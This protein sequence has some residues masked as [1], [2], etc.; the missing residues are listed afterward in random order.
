MRTKQVILYSLLLIALFTSCNE[1]R[2]NLAPI[3]TLRLSVDKNEQILTKGAITEELLKVYIV[4]ADGDT[5]KSYHDYVK[6]VRNEKLLLPVGTYTVSVASNQAE[7]ADWEK[8]FYAGEETVEVK[9]GEIT[10]ATV[11][12]KIANTKVSVDYAE[13]LKENFVNYETTVSNKSGTLLYA[14]DEYRAGYFIPEKLTVSLALTNNN[15]KEYTIRY[16]LTDIK[17]RYH[18]TIKF[19]IGDPPATPEGGSDFDIEVDDK[20]KVVN[21][22]IVIHENDLEGQKIPVIK[23]SDAFK[24]SLLSIKVGED[25][26]SSSLKITSQVGI[27]MLTVKAESDLF[28]TKDLGL[29]DL[30]HL[31]GMSQSELE[32]LGFPLLPQN[33]DLKDITLDFKKLNEIFLQDITYEQSKKLHVFTVYAMDSLHQETELKFTIEAKPDVAIYVE[34]PNIWTT[35]AVLKGFCAE[36]SYFKLQVAGGSVIDVKSVSSDG[37]GNVSALVIGLK[38][39]VSYKY[40]LVSEEN[41]DMVCEPKEFTIKAPS[42]VPNFGFENWGKH[43][44]YLDA[45]LVGGNKE[46]ISPNDENYF[47]ESGNLGAIA[48]SEILTNETSQTALSSSKKAAQLTSTWAGAAGIGAYAAGSIYSGYPKSVS[49]S[50]AELVYGRTYQGFPTK[51]RGY[52]KYEPHEIGDDVDDRCPVKDLKGK[53]DQGIIYIALVPRTFNIVS[54]TSGTIVAFNKENAKAFAYGEYIITETKN[55]T[56]KEVEGVLGGYAPFEITLN[57]N[58][59]VPPT[60]QFYIVIVATASRYGDYFTGARGSRLCVDEFSLDYDYDEKAFSQ[61]G[62][63]NLTPVRIN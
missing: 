40:W 1:D 41:P 9:A 34:S 8:P 49:S 22:E 3:G 60:E 11:V 39:S 16:V 2:G 25:L 44:G 21:C 58:N 38:Q 54:K 50:G 56:G 4:N 42:V 15:G 5:I 19:K 47:W 62:L 12:C 30:T 14:R 24:E 35:F 61:T 7:D 48:G 43:T 32:N 52:Y 63:K 57:Y 23:L 45:P 37:D 51:L 31:D 59:T 13:K 17:P 29:F 53:M 20:A 10:S 36:K 6:E 18:Y 26:P 46:Y 27:K 55:D 33:Q 28:K